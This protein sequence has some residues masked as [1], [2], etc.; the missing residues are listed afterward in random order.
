MSEIEGFWK[1]RE[2]SEEGLNEEEGVMK[3]EKQGERERMWWALVGEAPPSLLA[4]FYYP[5]TVVMLKSSLFPFSFFSL[6]LSLP[7]SIT[8]LSCPTS[9]TTHF[10]HSRIFTSIFHSIQFQSILPHNPPTM[11]TIVK[12][13]WVLKSENLD[14]ENNKKKKKHKN[15]HIFCS[16]P[17]LSFFFVQPL[18]WVRKEWEI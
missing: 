9:L 4:V 2:E 1:E 15:V 3:E 12:H 6:S 5:L 14:I 7:P 10:L 18:I 11:K 13:K 16:I 8:S 17:F